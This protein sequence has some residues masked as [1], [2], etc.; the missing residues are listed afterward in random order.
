MPAWDRQSRISNFFSSPERPSPRSSSLLTR[1]SSPSSIG[2][3][4]AF[5]ETGPLQPVAPVILGICALDIKARSRAMREILIRIVER[6][7][8]TIEVKVFGDKVI[9]DEGT[10][11]FST[12]KHPHSI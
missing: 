4:D 5:Q 9:L 6:S 1:S 11:L 12:S 3:H 10:Q 8:G 7:R 2:S